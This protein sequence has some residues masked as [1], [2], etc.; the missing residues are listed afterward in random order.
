[1]QKRQAAAIVDKVQPYHSKAAADPPSGSHY[2][3]Q[4][5]HAMI[6]SELPKK[7]R[8]PLDHKHVAG[9]HHTSASSKILCNNYKN[10]FDDVGL[11]P[12]QVNYGRYSCF[13]VGI[14]S[15]TF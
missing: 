5:Q 12:V 11:P 8:S 15:V 10:N 6:G 7:T 14:E 4:Q 3:E 2:N 1:M 9:T 13:I